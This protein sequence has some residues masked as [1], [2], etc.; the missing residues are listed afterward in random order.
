MFDLKL[1]LCIFFLFR[2]IHSTKIIS[3]P[4]Y[5]TSLNL[6]Q[7]S[8]FIDINIFTNIKLGNNSETLNLTLSY[9]IQSFLIKEKLIPKTSINLKCKT[10]LLYRYKFYLTETYQD[11]LFLKISNLKEEKKEEDFYI[12][13]Y[14]YQTLQD[15]ISI[16]RNKENFFGLHSQIIS[17][18]YNNNFMIQL[19]KKNLINSYDISLEFFDDNK[20]QLIIGGM[21]HEYNQEYDETNFIH[22]NNIYSSWHFTFTNITHENYFQFVN[23]SEGHLSLSYYGFVSPSLYQN[24][25]DTIFFNK[26][27]EEKKCEINFYEGDDNLTIYIC[28]KNINIKKFPK[29][30]FWDKEINFTFV[31]EGYELFKQFKKDKLIF[32]IH[33][34]KEEKKN[35]KLGQIFLKKY[36]IICNYDKKIIGFY[37]QKK[38]KI[39][40]FYFI[41]HLIYFILVMIIIILIYYLIKNKKKV[42]R[43][44]HANELEDN[45]DYTP[46]KI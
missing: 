23:Y 4:I 5:K 9:E 11:S 22:E 40:S 12:D 33:F 19:K 6:N 46:L 41:N 17:G 43:K 37:T 13:K 3:I 38:G 34:N 36:K 8:E 29:L 42:L 31:F 10:T 27:F 44:I 32:L 25:I 1:Y 20:G 39:F 15:D 18:S 24:I 35:W 26:L 14:I 7:F 2:N 30:L 45:Y 16:K 28:D 21:P